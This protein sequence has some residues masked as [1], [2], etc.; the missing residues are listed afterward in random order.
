MADTAERTELDIEFEALTNKYLVPHVTEARQAAEEVRDIQKQLLSHMERGTDPADTKVQDLEA[1]KAETEAKQRDLEEQIRQVKLEARAEVEQ[2]TKRGGDWTG[3]LFRNIRAI[4]EAVRKNGSFEDAVNSRAI[5][6]SDI[7]TAGKIGPDLESQFIQW[8]IGKQAAL[9]RVTVR[10]MT[11]PTARLDE[12][13]VGTRKLRAGAEAQAPALADGVS[14]AKRDL[15]T[16][17]VVWPEDISRSFLE[18]NIEGAQAEA[19]ITQALATAFGNDSNDLFWNGDEDNSDDFIGIND[20]IIDIAK[21]DSSVVDSDATSV[22]TAQAVLAAALRALPVDYA[23]L[24]LAFFGPYKFVLSYADEIADRKT[25][26]GD[27]ALVGGVSQA[28][29]FGVPVVGDAHLASDE[30][31]LSPLA[32]LVW[33]VQRGITLETQWNAR[34]RAVEVTVSAR[35]DQNYVKSGAVVLVDNIEASLR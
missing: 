15:A 19:T 9:S 18:D 5:D 29:Y 24:P 27:Q 12:M 17:E 26:M 30:A 22:T 20:G 14:F 2:P 6:T 8:L 16:V 32:N 11:S 31:V 35:T 33:G 7:A 25:V 1:F 34:K 3:V 13:V 10:R 21:A 23:A 4:Q 28:T